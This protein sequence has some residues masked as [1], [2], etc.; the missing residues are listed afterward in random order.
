MSIKS[1]QFEHCTVACTA[2]ADE[3]LPGKWYAMVEVEGVEIKSHGPYATAA[4]ALDIARL[5]CR[6]QAENV[7]RSRGIELPE[8]VL[9]PT[10]FE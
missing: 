6:G 8:R 2:S 9:E 7:A 10:R 1:D 3:S 4:K 5:L